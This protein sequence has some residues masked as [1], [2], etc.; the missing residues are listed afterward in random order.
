MKKFLKK[1][2]IYFL[3][4][5]SIQI[6]DKFNPKVIAIVGNV[7]KTSTKDAIKQICYPNARA[8]VGN[9][10]TEI[11]VP[12]SILGLP[13][14]QKSFYGW[15]KNLLKAQWMVWSL[16]EYEDTIIL[17]IAA[18]RPGDIQSIAKWLK[19]DILCMTY[20]PKVPVHLEKFKTL[21]NVLEEKGSI[22]NAVKDGG[23]IVFNN[24]DGHIDRFKSRIKQNDIKILNVG[25]NEN[26][27]FRAKN[28]KSVITNDNAY[29][30]FDICANDICY[31]IQLKDTVG[32]QSV[33]PILYTF[34]IS[35]FTQSIETQ[36][37][38]HILEKIKRYKAPSR[39][40]QFVKG[41]H[42]SKIIDDTYNSSPQALKVMLKLLKED[43]SN[44]RKVVIIGDMKELGKYS[45]ES[46]REAGKI[47]AEF[48]DFFIGVGKEMKYAVD[49]AIENGMKNVL[50]FKTSDEAS[51]V[52]KRI[53]KE[54]DLIL[55]KGSRATEMEKVVENI[56]Y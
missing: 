55:V 49:A 6:L 56:S 7:G 21:E 31:R 33:Y 50:H 15:L 30:S 44:C 3:T 18:D 10:N 43:M 26:S 42:N 4:Q 36:G 39:R 28:I 41:I 22:I 51:D 27:K 46:H 32:D 16:K 17:E 54:N 8:T 45:K 34:A 40:S 24:D 35:I 19:I 53:I 47:I 13:N 23:L 38:E 12:L 25:I 9:F 52:A 20:I 14:M 1:V 11:G 37:I 29:I 48:S 2:V 5:K